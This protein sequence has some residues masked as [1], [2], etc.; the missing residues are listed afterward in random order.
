VFAGIP[1]KVI[2]SGAIEAMMPGGLVRFK[3]M[4]QFIAAATGE[5]TP[6]A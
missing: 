1:Y 3:D 2:D 5:S 6:R 4:D